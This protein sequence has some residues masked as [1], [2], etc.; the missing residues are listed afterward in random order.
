M[1]IINITGYSLDE[2]EQ[3]AK[4]HLIKKQKVNHG[5]ESYD[6]DLSENSLKKNN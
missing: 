3:I 2:K 5:L 6:F 1:E 4:K